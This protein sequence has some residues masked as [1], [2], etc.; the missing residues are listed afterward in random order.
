MSDKPTGW[1]GLTIILGREEMAQYMRC[2]VPTIDRYIKNHGFPAAPL[3]SGRLATTATLIAA[4]LEAR[5]KLYR[6]IKEH[7]TS[8]R[9]EGG[10]AD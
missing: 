9:A 8:E 3:P 4:W 5:G 1:N 2:S 7:G 10:A 6:E